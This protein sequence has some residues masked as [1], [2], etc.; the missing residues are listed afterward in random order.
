MVVGSNGASVVVVANASSCV[1]V[2]CGSCAE[3]EEL[4]VGAAED[5]VEVVT[6]SSV[7]VV[8]SVCSCCSVELAGDVGEAGEEGEAGDERLAAGVV[9]C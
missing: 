1:E 3:L 6:S 5:E 9:C 8:L 2:G 4:E 7:V